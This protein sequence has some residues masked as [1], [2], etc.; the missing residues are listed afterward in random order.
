MT[1]GLKAS[2]QALQAVAQVRG[3]FLS[4]GKTQLESLFSLS[5][6]LFDN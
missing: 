1:Q 6:L 4:G 3:F 2:L 5:R